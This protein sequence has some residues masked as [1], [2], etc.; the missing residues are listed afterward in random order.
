MPAK[1]KVF[2]GKR[3]EWVNSALTK[4]GAL[5]LVKQYRK[6]R[7][8]AKV[9]PMEVGYAIYGRPYKNRT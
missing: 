1:Y 3:Y 6:K 2:N 7:W 9:I 5:S 8:S 4:K